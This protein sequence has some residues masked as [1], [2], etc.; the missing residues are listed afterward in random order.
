MLLSKY[1]KITIHFLEDT[2]WGGKTSSC[3][4]GLV[5]SSLLTCTDICFH[6]LAV[7]IFFSQTCKRAA[8]LKIKKTERIKET[9]PS[10]CITSI[11]CWRILDNQQTTHATRL[12]PNVPEAFD[13]CHI[14]HMFAASNLLHYSARFKT[15]PSRPPKT[16]VFLISY[17]SKSTNWPT[18]VKNLN[19]FG[20]VYL[21]A[22]KLGTTKQLRACLDASLMLVGQTLV[23]LNFW[24]Y[25]NLMTYR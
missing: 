8:C 4:I 19:P 2:L 15:P 1:R 11:G 20:C 21:I 23:V 14:H 6:F 12:W 9:H 18:L 13:R 17:V 24:L 22:T 3:C 7:V 25:A 10:P 5:W 16:Q